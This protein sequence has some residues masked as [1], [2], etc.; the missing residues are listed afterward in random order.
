MADVI[1]AIIEKDWDAFSVRVSLVAPFASWVHVYVSDGS[2]GIARTIVDFSK[3][4]E[5]IDRYPKLSFEAHILAAYPEKFV[6]PLVDAGFTRLIAHVESNDPRRFLDEA[7]FDDIDIGIAIDGATEIREVEPF[8][9]EIDVVVVMTKETGATSDAFLP[10]GV[11]KVKLIR[12]NFP[13][14]PIEVVGGINDVTVKSVIE[15]GA[16]RIVSSEYVFRDPSGIGEAI[17]TLKTG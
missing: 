17:E 1:P 15:A 12:Q 6:R 10:E 3:L 5:L 11:E 4:S 8:L 7:K 16:T 9:E 13:D 2:I 14:L